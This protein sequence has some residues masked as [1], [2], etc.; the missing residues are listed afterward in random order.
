MGFLSLH[1]N[2]GRMFYSQNILDQIKSQQ[3]PGKIKLLFPEQVF[4]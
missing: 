1:Q 3:V 2:A 4:S